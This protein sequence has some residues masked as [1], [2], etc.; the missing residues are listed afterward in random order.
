[1]SRNRKLINN[2]KPFRKDRA[3]ISARGIRQF[4]EPLDKPRYAAA[5]QADFM[6]DDDYVIGLVHKGEVRAYPAWIVDYYHVVNDHIAGDPVAM[7]S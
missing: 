3:I 5:D 7:F 6:R 1:M 2:I 4:L